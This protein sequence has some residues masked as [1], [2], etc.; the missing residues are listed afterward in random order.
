M[1]LVM[2]VDVAR[3]GGRDGGWKVGFGFGLDDGRNLTSDFGFVAAAGGT[4][5]ISGFRTKKHNKD[6]VSKLQPRQSAIKQYYNNQHKN[7]L[8]CVGE[9]DFFF[10]VGIPSSNL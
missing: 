1:D 2:I 5:K 9:Y 8:L 7:Q 6:L 10:A 4:S 3:M